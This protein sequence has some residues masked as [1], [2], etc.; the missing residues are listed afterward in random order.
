[1]D[2]LRHFKQSETFRLLAQ[3]LSGMW[4]VEKLSDQLSYLAD[5]L[6]EQTLEMVWAGTPR[7]HREQPA[8]SVIAYG[9]LGGKELGYAS[10]LDIVFLYDDA[11]PDAQDVYSRLGKRMNTWL[12]TLTSAGMLYEIDMRL[13]PDGASGLLVSS[14]EAFED[15][16]RKHAWT[17]EHQALSR[18]RYS[19][20][21]AAVG[22]KF[23]VI[24]ET[25]LR[26]PRDT[27]KL[28]TEVLEMREKMHAGHPNPTALFDLK[29]DSGGLVDVEFAVQ[30][31][32][33]AHAHDHAELT[34]NIGNIALLKRCAE[35][36]L[37]QTDTAHAAA[38]AYR[39]L[40]RMQHQAK[41]Q[42]DEAARIDADLVPGH[43]EAVKRLCQE[44]F[45]P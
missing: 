39:E 28:R 41:L 9:K 45:A 22:A 33:L 6:L 31:L 1:M 18:A 7:K 15:Y 12:G 23:D 10:D 36:G 40:R 32:V 25:I 17:W 14:V 26:L 8:F 37:L 4:S 5:L 35:L 42:G 38:D 24:R 13:R 3:D 44:V 34:A 43:G 20:G 11:H 29:H 21:D 27:E 2:E 16:Q 30:Y 19:C